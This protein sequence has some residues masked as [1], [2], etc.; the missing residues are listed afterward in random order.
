MN[1]ET[2]ISEVVGFFHTHTAIAVALIVA[3]LILAYFKPK[4]MFKLLLFVFFAVAVFYVLSLFGESLQTGTQQKVRMN[5][6]T[7]EA[8]EGSR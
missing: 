6:K 2:L 4:P 1:F 5:K 3:L 8:I 7:L